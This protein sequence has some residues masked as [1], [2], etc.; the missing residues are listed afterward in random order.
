VE[1]MIG[2][3]ERVE[4]GRGE[5]VCIRAVDTIENKKSMIQNESK[6]GE[7]QKS[8]KDRKPRVH[9]IQL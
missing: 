6:D 9:S 4:G 2:E 3:E 5:R 7:K 8:K 1:G